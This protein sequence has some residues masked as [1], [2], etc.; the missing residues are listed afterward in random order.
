MER[1]E[2]DIDHLL[3]LSTDSSN[4]EGTL[5]WE[6]SESVSG[7]SSLALQG[8]LSGR[9]VR[10]SAIDSDALETFS[11]AIHA[12]PLVA[13]ELV[14]ARGTP[15]I[16]GD[17]ATYTIDPYIAA[18][19]E[20]I[21]AR[22]DAIK[23]GNITRSMIEQTLDDGADDPECG[24]TDDANEPSDL[25]ET[26]PDESGTSHYDQMGFVVVQRGDTIAHKS[27]RSEGVDGCDIFGKTIPAHEGKLN[28]GF[29]DESI[30]VSP[31]G[32]CTALISGVLNA[33]ETSISISNHLS[34]NGDVDFTTGRITFP[35]SVSVKGSV[36]DR[37]F[38]HALKDIEIDG[39]VEAADL[40]S[41][42]SITL[43]RGM[44]GKDIG[45]TNAEQNLTAGYLESVI[46]TIKGNAIVNSEITNC[47]LIIRGELHAD[48]AALRGGAVEVSKTARIGSI[49]SVQG[50]KTEVRIGTLPDVERLIRN[51]DELL[52]QIERKIETETSKKERMDKAITKATP[53]QIEELMGLQFEIDEL[54]SRKNDLDTSRD[55]LLNLLSIHTQARLE[56][57]KAI[58]AKSV[59]YFPGYRCEFSN[60]LIG[61]SVITI[62]SNGKPTLNYL[63]KSMPLSE[64]ARIIPDDR[65]LKAEFIDPDLAEIEQIEPVCNDGQGP[66]DDLADGSALPNAA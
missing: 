32:V 2:H 59:L 25:P 16:H 23:A 27:E 18:Q 45:Q 8:Y 20:R 40:Q 53:Q 62:G 14:V 58:Y 44:A 42:Q 39:L 38:V 11:K 19:I 50:V 52:K 26:D 13:H 66:L 47:T 31:D 4:I 30:F 17:S 56:I 10:D 24:H 28:E 51:A 43:H 54:Q 55:I 33:T 36:R 49:G 9:N 65:I 15:P 41:D 6:P 3:K 29:L 1:G 34:V 57:T 48:S 61:E 12:E 37:F 5:I 63:G 7:I 64:R 22:A 35:G 46:G 21:S 60:D